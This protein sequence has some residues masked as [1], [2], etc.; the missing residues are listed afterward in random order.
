MIFEQPVLEEICKVLGDYASGSQITTYLNQLSI[1]D[2]NGPQVTKWKRIYNAFVL[3]QNT[4][5]SNNKIIEFILLECAPSRF[6]NKEEDFGKLLEQINLQLAFVGLELLETGKI[7]PVSKAETIS[8]AKKKAEN[9]KMKLEQRNAHPMIFQYCKSELLQNNYFHAVFEAMKGLMQRMRDISGSHLDGTNLI[10]NV[11]SKN[12]P[13]VIINNFQSQSEKDE[14]N[15]FCN[16]LKGLCSMFRNTE[17]H[18]PKVLWNVT[19]QDALEILA[20]VSYCHRRLDSA[21]KIRMIEQ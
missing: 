18:E 15:G 1:R 10:E 8:D 17:S 6:V 2:V 7:Q 5:Q 13:V 3:Y 20:I 19:E 14:H 4:F 11:F 16:L 9:L 21:Q 12:N